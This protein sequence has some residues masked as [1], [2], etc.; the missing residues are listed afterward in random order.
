MILDSNLETKKNLLLND[1]EWELIKRLV[2]ILGQFDTITTM[3]SG[4]EFVTLSLVS[5]ATNIFSEKQIFG[6]S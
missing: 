1:N 3:L 6:V 4:R 5:C 2:E